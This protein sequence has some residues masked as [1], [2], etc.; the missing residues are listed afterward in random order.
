MGGADESKANRCLVL[1]TRKRMCRSRDLSK[2]R[3]GATNNKIYLV[4]GM[5]YGGSYIGNICDLVM[6]ECGC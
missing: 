2:A 5:A 3:M 6:L 1:S 4:I